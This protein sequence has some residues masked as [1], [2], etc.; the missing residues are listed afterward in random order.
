VLNHFK[1]F[2]LMLLFY[3]A[4]PAF[5]QISND[6]IQVTIVLSEKRGSYEEFSNALDALL[7]ARHIP[8][9][10]IAATDPIPSSGLLIG[11]GTKAATAVAASD[12]TSVLN[13]LIS[14]ERQLSLLHDFPARA[15]AHT[16]AAIYLDQPISRQAHL[17]AALLPGKKNVGILYS[18][19]PQAPMRQTLK[20]LNLN[21]QEQAVDPA[22]PLPEAL[23]AILSRSEVLLALPDA[24]VYNDTT[25]RNILLS[26]FRSGIPLIGFSQ[27]YVKA[28]ALCA[29]Y[30]TPKQIASQAA[31]LILQYGVNPQQLV[32]Q[33]PLEFEVLVNEQVAR[34]LGIKVKGASALH[35]EIDIKEAP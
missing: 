11:V 24:P 34:S 4:S 16:F 33:Y 7:I 20:A 12:A 30:S 32:S 10:V 27:G 9:R 31:L 2:F 23:A 15:A 35:D 18:S 28:G 8:H 29:V 19:P 14:K 3:T 25:I 26:T 22:T 17:I 13:V 21:L 1:L 5:A 6:S